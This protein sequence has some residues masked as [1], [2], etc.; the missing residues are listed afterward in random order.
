MFVPIRRTSAIEEI[1]PEEAIDPASL[2]PSDKSRSTGQRVKSRAELERDEQLFFKQKG[3]VTDAMGEVNAA[4][5]LKR[6]RRSVAATD[7]D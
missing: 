6:M 5:E 1:R 3:F 4:E 2:S 7:E